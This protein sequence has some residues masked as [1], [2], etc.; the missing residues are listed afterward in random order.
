METLVSLLNYNE[1]GIPNIVR[2]VL[3]TGK[4][5][6][7]STLPPRQPKNSDRK[8]SGGKLVGT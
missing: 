6:D 4:W 8:N 7:G 3:I 2:E 1:H 5:V